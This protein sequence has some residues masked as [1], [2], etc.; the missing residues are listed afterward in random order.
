MSALPDAT[1]QSFAGHD[2]RHCNFDRHFFKLCDF[3]GANL[4]GASLRGVRFSGCDL[5]DA[6][7]RDTDLSY[8][9]FSSV[10][11]HDPEYGRTDVT[12]AHWEGANLRTAVLRSLIIGEAG[13][14]LWSVTHSGVAGSVGLIDGAELR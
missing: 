1:K 5:R 14:L 3:R 12:G 7:L 9:M 6:D 4:R 11:T 10:R 2:L 8:A 13:L